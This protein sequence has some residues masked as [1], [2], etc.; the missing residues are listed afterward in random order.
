MQTPLWHINAIAASIYQLK[1]SNRYA[2]AA[3]KAGRPCHLA[4][5]TETVMGM[6]LGTD[7]GFVRL[8]MDTVKIFFDSD[9]T[10]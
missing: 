1:M 3:A 10:S 9:T 5:L 8:S 2:S 4:M 7:A 6:A